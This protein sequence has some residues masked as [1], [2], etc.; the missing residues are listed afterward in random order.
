MMRRYHIVVGREAADGKLFPCETAKGG[1]LFLTKLAAN[2]TRDHLTR[3]TGREY[4]VLDIESAEPVERRPNPRKKMSLA[5]FAAW[6]AKRK[7]RD[8]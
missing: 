1:H 4:Q 6:G 7:R 2:L 8:P 3:A 5:D